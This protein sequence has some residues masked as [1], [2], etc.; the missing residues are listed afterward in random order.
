MTRQVQRGGD[1]ATQIQVGSQGWMWQEAPAGPEGVLPP[2]GSRP[3]GP[4]LIGCS[5]LIFSV[6][7]LLGVLIGGL[8]L[9]FHG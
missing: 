1:G 7:C 4:L 8:W 6:A 5:A 2:E 9:V 3:V